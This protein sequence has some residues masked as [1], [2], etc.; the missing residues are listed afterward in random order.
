[1]LRLPPFTYL[2]PQSLAEAVAMI[3][4]QG[5]AEAMLVAGGTDLYPNMKRQQY[6][7]KRLI[8][9]R[10][11]RELQGLTG[12]ARDGVIIGAGMTLTR[13]SQQRDI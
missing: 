4:A 7:P 10:Q 12:N 8:G 5:P 3:A 1:M 13:V 9:L 11:L 2:S 6:E